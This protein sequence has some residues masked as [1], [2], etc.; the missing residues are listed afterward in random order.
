M[1]APHDVVRVVV[2]RRGGHF[3]SMWVAV[4]V[5]GVTLWRLVG[6][7][8]ALVPPQV[9]VGVEVGPQRGPQWL[10]GVGVGVG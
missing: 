5:L 9:G 2:M 7:S 4:R 6:V 3:L 8:L 10:G 1:V